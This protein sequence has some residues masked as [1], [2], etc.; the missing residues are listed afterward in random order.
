MFNRLMTSM[1][2]V[3]AMIMTA[4]S[5]NSFKVKGVVE[6]ID[7]GDTL[8]VVSDIS[9]LPL[10]TLIVKDGKFEWKGESD[11]TIICNIISKQENASVVF[12][13][14]PGTINIL[15]S[16]SGKSE[17]SGT[18]ANDALQE[19]NDKNLEYQQKIDALMN[20]IYTNDSIT[21]EQQANLY[22]QYESLLNEMSQA[23]KD[24]TIKNL[25]NEMGYVLLVQLA[26][27]KAFSKDELA[28]I[29][30]KLPSNY[31]NRKDIKDIQSMIDAVFST[32]VGDKISDFC[33]RTPAGEE[34]SILNL[35]KENKVTVLDFWASWCQPCRKEMP[36][37][38]QIL[39]KYKENGFGIV[40]ISVDDNS[41]EWISCV[42]ELE[43]T[44][45]QISDLAGNRSTV[46]KSFNISTIPF[47]AVVNQDGT[48]IAKG[49]KIS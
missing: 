16:S 22:Y 7:D 39:D 29:I 10:D 37:M 43:L 19:L 32:E 26:Y 42:E 46:A 17:I 9:E 41:E 27:E 49:L 25:D 6:D 1:F 36:F 30:S 4:C 13:R 35:I 23:V 33:M 3:A 5:S 40:G 12:F 44:W 14:E 28:D 38:K 2:L 15:L 8:L 20:N 24:L 11:S 47:T 21:E 31:L 45:P 34:V 48:I 18:K